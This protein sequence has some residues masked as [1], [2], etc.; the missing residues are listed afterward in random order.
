MLVIINIYHPFV[1]NNQRFDEIKNSKTVENPTD[2][3][4]LKNKFATICSIKLL[5]YVV[6]F[7]VPKQ[8]G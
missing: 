4:L 2:Y 3:Q 1:C 7:I 8:A 5:F 6:I